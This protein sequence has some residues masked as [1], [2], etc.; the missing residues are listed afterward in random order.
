MIDQS[1]TRAQMWTAIV[2]LAI[3]GAGIIGVV[4]IEGWWIGVIAL[5]ANAATWWMVIIGCRDELRP[6]PRLAIPTDRV[7]REP[8]RR[9]D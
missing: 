8:L 2:M 4:T 9:R 6:P 5:C 7:V 1:K 3:T